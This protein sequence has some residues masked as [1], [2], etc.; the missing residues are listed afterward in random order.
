M[1]V[2][3]ENMLSSDVLLYDA[4]CYLCR[5]LVD[6]AKKHGNDRSLTFRPWDSWQEYAHQWPKEVADHVDTDIVVVTKDGQCLT[7]EAAWTYAVEH[8]PYLDKVQWVAQ[9]VGL[10]SVVPQTV[11]RIG[12]AVRKFCSRCKR[13]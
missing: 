2:N 1:S 11:R 10:V 3:R 9:R 4:D 5:T 8:Y 12:K 13:R 7:G 6:F